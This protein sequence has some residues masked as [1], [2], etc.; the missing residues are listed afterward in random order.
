MIAS[1][2]S[3]RVPSSG[4]LWNDTIKSYTDRLPPLVLDVHVA[5]AVSILEDAQAK[6]EGL[7]DALVN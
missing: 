4:N 2:Q 7:N 6:R 5:T 1:A 3:G